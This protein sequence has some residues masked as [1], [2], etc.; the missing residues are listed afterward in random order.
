MIVIA[1]PGPVKD[2]VVLWFGNLSWKN[3]DAVTALKKHYPDAVIAVENDAN[4]GALGEVHNL[5]SIPPCV[6][7]TTISTGIGMGIITNGHLNQSLLMNEG[8]HAIV[9]YDG[10]LR[11]WEKFA[12]GK[13]IFETYGKF[14]KD[15]RDKK[16]W[17]QIADRISRGFLAQIPLL[18]PDLVIIGGSMGAHF[19]KYQDTL[20]GIMNENLPVGIPRPNFIMATNP[21]EA[22]IYGCY[23]Y[24][25]DLAA[26]H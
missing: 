14:G 23:H 25:R 18:Q 8:G 9:E 3:F 26:T 7:Y 22:V 11:D 24:A 13:T 16:T 1:M 5:E 21:D 4:L 6:V 2:N 15:I 10:V 12:S 19:A 20:V 17:D